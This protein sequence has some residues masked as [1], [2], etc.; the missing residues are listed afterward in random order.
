MN[1]IYFFY[2]N[3][4]FVN[5][6]RAFLHTLKKRP[7]PRPIYSEGLSKIDIADTYNNTDALSLISSFYKL[8]L[9]IPT[10]TSHNIVTV[11]NAEM[12]GRTDMYL[13]KFQDK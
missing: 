11:K 12:E 7:G 3:Q 4:T 10:S 5:S 13:K 6:D 1:K 2:W 9:K 8:H